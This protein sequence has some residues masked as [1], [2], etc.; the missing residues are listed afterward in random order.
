MHKGTLLV[1]AAALCAGGT[2]GTAQADQLASVNVLGLYAHVQADPTLRARHT[3]T[4][5]TRLPEATTVDRT[6][7]VRGWV[8]PVVDAQIKVRPDLVLGFPL[9]ISGK[10]V[11]TADFLRVEGTV[12]TRVALGPSEGFGR[13]GLVSM[14]TTF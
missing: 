12:H 10:Q 3:Y 2:I 1:L 5:I 6:Y 13:G 4:V 11:L 9:G 14:W 8:G 7:D